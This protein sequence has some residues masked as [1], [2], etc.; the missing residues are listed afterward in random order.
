MYSIYV[1]INW[2][3]AKKGGLFLIFS[4]FIWFYLHVYNISHPSGKTLM[5]VSDLKAESKGNVEGQIY[6]MVVTNLM[7]TGWSKLQE[8]VKIGIGKMQSL[9]SQNIR[10]DL[11]TSNNNKG[12]L[13][14][15][16]IYFCLIDCVWITNV[17]EN[18]LNRWE[19]QTTL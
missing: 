14:W 7:D 11:T 18:S 2:N 15:Q 16:N 3:T 1:S 12:D 4:T 6:W 5:L 13:I 19:Y 9:G 8:M 10:Q 17:M